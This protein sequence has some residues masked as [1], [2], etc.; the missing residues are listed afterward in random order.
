MLLRDAPYEITCD[1]DVD[2][3]VDVGCVL[4]DAPFSRGKDSGKNMVRL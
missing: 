4:K 1:V 2:V 3:D